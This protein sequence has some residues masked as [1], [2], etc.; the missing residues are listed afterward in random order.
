MSILAIVFDESNIEEMNGWAN[1]IASSFG[2]TLTIYYI[3]TCSEN[4]KIDNL[5]C[6]TTEEAL[7]VIK[8]EFDSTSIK[9]LLLDHP[10][11]KRGKKA[12][13]LNKFIELGYC[14]S[15]TLRFPSE[16]GL[17][18]NKI[19]VPTA[20]G[21]NS[22]E[23]LKFSEKFIS[24]TNDASLD[25]LF[26]ESDVSELSEEV[27]MKR[28]ERILSESG[29]SEGNKAINPTVSLGNDISAVIHSE[30]SS[31][32]YDL[33]LL[34][35][36]DSGLLNRAFFG[37]LTDRLLREDGKVAVGVF[38]AASNVKE[39][40]KLGFKKIISGK[41]PQL[42]RELRVT[43]FEN[44]EV[45]SKWSF[46]FVAL[47]SF[48]TALAALGLMLNSPAVIIGAMLVAPL[49]TPILGAALSLIQ[50]NKVLMVD[51]SKSLLFGY[52]SALILGVLLGTFGIFYGVTDQ[53]QSRSEPDVPDMLIAI[54]SG[55]AAAYCYARPRLVSALAGVAIA[56][57][58][59]PPIATA[60]IAIA[61]NE[62]KIAF[63][64]T[65]L[66][67]TN[68][69]FIIIGAGITF[70][71]LGIR[72]KKNQNSL[73]IWTRRF[74]LAI[75]IV[76][77]IHIVPLSS[78][79]MSKVSSELS[80]NENKIDD[81]EGQIRQLIIKDT[82]EDLLIKI[83]VSNDNNDTKILLIDV[84]SDEFKSDEIIKEMLAV[85]DKFYKKKVIIRLRKNFDYS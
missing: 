62:Q 5:L 74:A 65:L 16:G 11:V 75:V 35:A 40:I 59:I 71:M 3:G 17:G 54:I 55:M 14:D 41:I 32:E 13:L 29:F 4:T 31:G 2:Q 21:S 45:N 69:V 66:F 27:G 85:A 70:L 63:G 46:D 72:A 49:M 34:G 52:F 58:L 47:T 57:A 28:L 44:V 50:G 7:T 24:D 61:M 30:A 64:A 51:C 82:G 15:I 79:L 67:T 12:D 73:N 56:A 1:S 6:V 68:V 60:G 19:L 78:V 10:L 25:V 84:M 23:A 18:G 53:M 48:S 83:E 43:I 39:K 80:K 38:R 33:V 76:A 77:A 42:N 26:V 8:K 20:G 9:L 37:T 22:I 36:S 81:L